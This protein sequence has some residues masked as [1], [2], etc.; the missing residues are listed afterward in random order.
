M[1]ELSIAELT[2]KVTAL[3]ESVTANT[4]TLSTLPG[5]VD[6]FYYL[7]VGSL[8]FFMQAGFGLLEAG[9][10]RTKNTKNILLKNL[11]DA[12]IGAIVWWAWG[13]AVAYETGKTPNKFI[14]GTDKAKGFFASGWVDVASEG[15]TEHPQGGTFALWFFQYVFAAAAATIVSGAVAERAQLTA[16]LIYSTVITGLIY[17][18]V[19]HWVWDSNGWASAFNTREGDD[20]P[21]LGGQIDFAGS[22]VVHMT[23]GVAAFVGALVIGPR[24]G[25]SDGGGRTGKPVAIKG[26]SSVLQAL[27]T[28]ILWMG[29]Y[30]FNPGSTPAITPKG[31]ATVLPWHAMLIGIIGGLVYIGGSRPE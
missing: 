19:V 29:W 11:L 18:V 9:S 14:G 25:R 30:G 3:E 20:G 23:G 22:G 28:F 12:C 1:S 31:C 8:V 7:F 2:A 6:T 10:V 5:S 24:I 26:H 27:G 21:L 13:Y 17:P 4:G 15:Y 16:Y